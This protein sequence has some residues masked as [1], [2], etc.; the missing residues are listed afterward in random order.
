MTELKA[1]LLRDRRLLVIE[2]DYTIA[3]EL[4]EAL[5]AHGAQVIG[6]AGPVADA[7]ALIAAQAEIDGAVLDIDL[8][9]EGAYPVADALRGR[10]VPFV[11]ATGYDAWIIPA[12]YAAVPR[13]EKPV[14]TRARAR[15][16]MRNR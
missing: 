14:D 12:A 11:F 9:G 6:P 1:D 8:H 4:A 10:G 13:C 7:L 2:D 15:L 16:L 3:S 5:E